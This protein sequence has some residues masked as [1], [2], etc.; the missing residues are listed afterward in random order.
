MPEGDTIFR[1]AERLQSWF[2]GQT[3]QGVDQRRSSLRASELT[4]S[5]FSN[6]VNHGKHLLMRFSNGLTLHSHLKMTGTW[7]TGSP[8]GNP[9]V[10]KLGLHFPQRT[11]WGVGLPILELYPTAREGH[12]LQR[13][14]PD[15]IRT[16][17]QA[18]DLASFPH[19]PLTAALLKQTIAA[20]LGNIYAVELPF[21]FGLSPFTPLSCLESPLEVWHFGQ[22]LLKA[23]ACIG[24]QTTTG[25]R[26]KPLLHHVYGKGGRACGVCRGTIAARREAETSWSR[27]VWWCP[28]CQPREATRPNLGRALQLT[29]RH[30]LALSIYRDDEERLA[31][32]RAL[33]PL[34][35]LALLS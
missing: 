31:L 2:G 1:L 15:L 6:A 18:H 23:N 17:K 29:R 7:T 8:G 5:Q 19:L 22:A 21:L 16:G 34:K 4:D 14:G 12:R 25:F 20:G 33:P 28:T 27:S 35:R 3:V 24:P 32:V 11:L 10:P 13:L 30:R 9:N 26:H